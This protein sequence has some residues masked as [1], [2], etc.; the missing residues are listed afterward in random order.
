MKGIP[1][2]LAVRRHRGSRACEP[3]IVREPSAD[4]KLGIVFEQEPP[5]GDK[6][7]RGNLVTIRVSTGPP[8]TVVPNVVGQSRDQ[9]V[10]ELS[11][12]DLEANVVPINSLEPVDTVLAQSP[13]AGTELIQGSTV[14]INVSKGPKPVT[15]PNVVG[16]AFESAQSALQGVGFAVAREDVE[17]S[18]PE[19]T[20]V[21]QNPAAGTEAGQGLGDHAPGLAGSR[22][23]RRSR[24]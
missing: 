12:A 15:V 8:K 10:A 19:G 4:A 1:E 2:R 20:V 13:K 6:I 24:T 7:E 3:N 23:R 17:A 22:P 21:G 16:S 14:R 18:E 5:P 9:A 11:D